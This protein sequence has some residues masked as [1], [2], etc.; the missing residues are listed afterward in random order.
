MTES[1]S[2]SIPRLQGERSGNSSKGPSSLSQQ[3]LDRFEHRFHDLVLFKNSHNSPSTTH[4]QSAPDREGLQ[5]DCF[6]AA[7]YLPPCQ[8]LLDL[9]PAR[10]IFAILVTNSFS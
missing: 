3:I 10:G 2:S 5:A 6:Q 1:I 7:A 8:G 9:R 4:L